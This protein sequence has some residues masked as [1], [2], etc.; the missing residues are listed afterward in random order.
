MGHKASTYKVVFMVRYYTGRLMAGG[1]TMALFMVCACVFIK[2][3]LSPELF[4]SAVI[5]SVLNEVS[6]ALKDEI[7]YKINTNRYGIAKSRNRR[8]II[9]DSLLFKKKKRRKTRRKPKA[10]LSVAWRKRYKSLRKKLQTFYKLFK[11]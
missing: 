4:W 10:N 11:E 3:P 7:I 1:I 9:S 8:Y 5:F 6:Q 2:T